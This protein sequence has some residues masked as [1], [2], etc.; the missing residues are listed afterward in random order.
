M[1]HCPQC[2]EP[3]PE[4]ARACP[5]CGASLAARP[6]SPGSRTI[7]GVSAEE[8]LGPAAGAAPAR[9][10]APAAVAPSKTNRTIVGMSADVLPKAGKSGH[11]GAAAPLAGKPGGIG[12]TIVGMNAAA[13]AG[14]R[15]AAGGAAPAGSRPAGAPGASA[16]LLGVARPGIAPLA[17]GVAHDDEPPDPPG[18]APAQELGAT[19]GPAALHEDALSGLQESERRRRRRR[20]MGAQVLPGLRVPKRPEERSS[21]RT[22]AIA[23]TAGALALAAVLVALFWPSPPPLTARAKADAGGHEGVEVSCKSCP[24]G[25]KVTIGAASALVASGT[26]LVPMP[27][28]L[29]VGENRLK[30]TVDRPAGGRSE[31]VGVTVSVAYRVRPDLAT[32]QAERPAFQVLAE[33]APGTTITID[34]RKVP[35]S[36]GHGVENVDVTDACTGLAAEVKTLSR[37]VPYVIKPEDGP[38]EQGLVNISVGIVPLWLDAPVPI[39]APAAAPG[40]PDTAAPVPHVVVDGP[41]FVL[42]GRT[43]KGA[44]VL[45]A[46]RPITV[47]PDGTF[48]QVM[49]VS[50]VGATQIDVRARMAGM[51]PRIAQI[52]V[53]R[54]ESLDKAARDFATSESPLAYAAV[55][56]DITG[57]VGRAVTLS[58]DVSET[59]KQGYL[60]VMLL[61]VSSGCPSGS[62]CAVRLV[63]AGDNPAKR[64]DTLRVFGH[65]ARAFKSPGHSD[66]PEIEV[67]FTLK[68]SASDG[69]APGKRP[70]KEPR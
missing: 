47:H 66:V 12:R 5:F 3:P 44:D 29:S 39:D 1:S 36:N 42:A 63:Q 2:G 7:V 11:G 61:E 65:V 21:R 25:T 60:T 18:Y 34:G 48:A 6:P 31:T 23:F 70:A 9:A 30:V 35:L 51:A 38:V 15:P 50:S 68:G 20:L 33:A 24:D 17:P 59:K 54:V 16:T 41:S 52:R 55:A 64:G 43:M 19:I 69:G 26:A 49:N 40:A 58:G 46:G 27:S 56:Q 13:L 28:A 4:G 45:A 10:P 53:R 67:D 14:A 32:L 37:Q 8:V 57:N 22:L 62:G